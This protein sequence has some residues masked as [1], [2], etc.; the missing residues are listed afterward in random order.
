MSQT[1]VEY[2]MSDKT[3]TIKFIALIALIIVSIILIFRRISKN[4]AIRINIIF[5]DVRIACVIEIVYYYMNGQLDYC[6]ISTFGMVGVI[7]A[8]VIYEIIDVILC[9]ICY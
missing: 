5:R 6:W 9:A 3:N 2:V 4:D 7:I 1:I 8:E